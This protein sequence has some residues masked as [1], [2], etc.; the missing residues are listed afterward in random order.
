MIS[1]N[2]NYNYQSKKLSI[3]NIEVVKIKYTRIKILLLISFIL[4]L[5]ILIQ[6]IKL[7]AELESLKYIVINLKN[8]FINED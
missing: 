1:Y 8:K 2:K 3:N 5:T 6:M 4:L 7:D